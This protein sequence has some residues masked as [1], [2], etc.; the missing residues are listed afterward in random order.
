M[1]QHLSPA[2]AGAIIASLVSALV[3]VVVFTVWLLKRSLDDKDARIHVLENQ[4]DGALG[5][6]ADNGESV[7]R[8]IETTLGIVREQRIISEMQARLTLPTPTTDDPQKRAGPQ[9]RP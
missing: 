3:S 6:I 9:T 5:R 1:L 8:S 2:D 7:A 4:I